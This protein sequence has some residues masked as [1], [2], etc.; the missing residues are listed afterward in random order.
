MIDRHSVLGLILARGGSKG[1]LCKNVRELAA[2]PLI[3]WTIETGHELEYLDQL[4]LSS[5]DEEIMTVAEEYDCEVPF[6][7]PAE[8]A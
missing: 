2:N 4:I 1:L 8:L 3:A 6:Q 7:R 5:D